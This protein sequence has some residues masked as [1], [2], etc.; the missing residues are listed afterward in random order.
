[1]RMLCVCTRSR[2]EGRESFLFRAHRSVRVA[3]THSGATGTLARRPRIERRGRGRIGKGHAIRVAWPFPLRNP[4]GYGPVNEPT[5]PAR[6]LKRARTCPG[7]RLR[8][9][10]WR[11]EEF[12]YTCAWPDAVLLSSHRALNVLISYDVSTRRPRHGHVVVPNI[13]PEAALMNGTVWRRKWKLRHGGV[14]SLGGKRELSADHL[15]VFLRDIKILLIMCSYAIRRASCLLTLSLREL[16]RR[17][18][19]SSHSVKQ[20]HIQ[21][22]G[23]SRHLGLCR[24]SFTQ[25]AAEEAECCK[26]LQGHQALRPGC[27]PNAGPRAGA[28]LRE[29]SNSPDWPRAAR[30]PTT[31]TTLYIVHSPRLSCIGLLRQHKTQYTSSINT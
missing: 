10:Q 3:S 22:N 16:L 13:P 7:G 29:N 20:N 19:R 31:R 26:S 24:R 4:R 27:P 30:S 12:S 5:P 2:S 6:P 28:A 25:R 1:M 8:A 21:F 11:P 15:S 14:R 18:P 9:V 17:W 23:H